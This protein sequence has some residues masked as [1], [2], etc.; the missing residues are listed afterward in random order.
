MSEHKECVRRHYTRWTYCTCEP[1]LVDRRKQQKRQRAGLVRPSRTTEAWAVIDALITAGWTPSAIATAADVPL[2]AIGAA[3]DKRRLTGKPSKWSHWHAERILSI[4]ADSTPT[5][6]YVHVIGARRRLQALGAIGYSIAQV[7]ERMA[8]LPES[9]LVPPLS[10]LHAIRNG[11]T[12]GR[13]QPG[14][15][16]V[17]RAVYR[18]LEHTPAPDGRSSRIAIHYATQRGWI[19]P[20]WWDEETIDDA[21][22]DA[23]VLAVDVDEVAVLRC[24][25]GSRHG[26]DLNIAEREEAVRLV[27]AEG[28]SDR[29]IAA[30]TRITDR[31]VF[32]I[33]HRLGLPANL[34]G[35][36]T[37]VA[38]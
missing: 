21:R 27:H 31:T 28:L 10:T 20:A 19:T 25:S 26:L 9:T 17:I 6:G 7:A 5:R 11:Q 16:R 18:E 3:L 36:P 30:R 8:E 32:R 22:A 29:Q 13:V 15:D 12:T 1:C 2:R 34:D 37:Q 14:I 23:T 35:L 4:N 38:G 33:R 24:A